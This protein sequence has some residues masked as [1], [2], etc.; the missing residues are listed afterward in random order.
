MAHLKLTITLLSKNY[1]SRMKK[2][3][4]NTKR[5]TLLAAL[6]LAITSISPL[7]AQFDRYR[8]GTK[9]DDEK[10]AQQNNSNQSAARLLDKDESN[11]EQVFG[12]T[13]TNQ[14][15]LPESD[16]KFVNLN[17]ETAFGPEVVTSFDFPN[18]SLVDLTKHMQKLTGIN[19]ILDKD[20]K[21][22]CAC[23]RA[24]MHVYVCVCVCVCA[25]VCECVCVFVYVH[26]CVCA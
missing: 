20:L 9:F 25:R 1:F 22:T 16:P 23:A 24:C 11:Q 13:N 18:A 2:M 4:K 3:V 17:P 8:T 7:Y 14:D 19:L 6:A 12:R 5:T 10:A 21:G 15:S 26:A